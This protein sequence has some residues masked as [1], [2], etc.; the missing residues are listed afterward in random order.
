MG[1]AVLTFPLVGA[2]LAIVWL[3]WPIVNYFRDPKGLRK[4]QSLFFLSGITDL[5][6]CY[7]SSRGFR[8]KSITE[9]HKNLN[10]PILRIGPNNLSFG[11]VSAIKDIYGH[12]TQCIKDLK[13]SITGGPH[14][15]IFDV[16]DK[17][18]HSEKR[19][20]LSAAFAIKNLV[21]WEYKVADTTA[22][23]LHAFDQRCTAPLP[24]NCTTPAKD[25]LTIDF[26]HWINLFT[27][28]AINV[29]AL[30]SKLG[31]LEQGDDLV[32]AQRMDKS[33]Y[34]AHYRK[35]QNKAAFATSHFVWDYQNFHLLTSISKLFPRWR[36]IWGDAEP[37]KDVIYHQTVTRLNRYQNGEKLD[38]FFAS[39]METKSGEPYNLEFGEILGDVGA[40]IDAGADTTAIA[41]TQVMEL[42]IR[43]PAHLKTLREEVDAVFENETVALFDKVRNL[44]FLRACLDEAMRIIPPTSAGLP[45][46]TPPEGAMILGEWIPGNTSVS[47]TAYATHHDPNVFLNP[48]E[49]NP[50]RWMDPA[51]RKRMEPYFIPFSTGGRGCIGRNISYLE[52]TIMLASLVHRYEFAL[53]SPEW[54]L[55]RFEAFNLLM[56]KMPMKI[57]RRTDV[58]KG[59]LAISSG[60]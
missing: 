3:I 56:G 4:Y 51:E 29:I 20:R 5:P 25:E 12:S 14:P 33:T 8:S 10:A 35:A 26:N 24:S 39:L 34:K 58:P 18:K 40:V 45:R 23:L 42:L 59:D 36:R 60:I 48:E 1:I 28:E 43:H 13:Y 15:N 49:F 54:K 47:M 11:D 7:V 27:I 19:K 32:T 44:P 6:Y 21:N 17:R 31:V 57:W 50:H 30:S 55:E 38:D 22:R 53:P 46:R 41:L 37:W 52:Q 2:Y 9:A 16:V